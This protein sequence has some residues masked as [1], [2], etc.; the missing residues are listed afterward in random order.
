M[1]GRILRE[2]PEPNRYELL[3]QMALVLMGLSYLA[4]LL[5][6]EEPRHGLPTHAGKSWGEYFSGVGRILSRRPDF[7][8]FLSAFLVADIPLVLFS[9]FLTRYGLGHP[10]VPE[11]VT[12]TFTMVFFGAS[13]LGSIA[14]GWFSD[15]GKRRGV[16]RVCPVLN[17]CAAGT[18]MASSRPAAVS[19]AFA[20]FGLAFGMRMV[21]VLPA[22]FRYAGPHR[23]S[24]Y[25]AL[26]LT[27]LGLVGF[28]M[29]P[30][31]GWMLDKGLI[32]FRGMFAA[33][34]VLS[35]I[36]W[37]MFVRIPVPAPPEDDPPE[38]F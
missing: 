13:A 36:A 37:A 6:E 38:R 2:F 25:S 1:V 17:L 30:P 19:V 21:A 7:R 23:R 10:N 14:A 31:V 16:F 22:V 8:M 27:V 29:P 20:F 3:V 26:T 34:A 9:T 18:A 11:G 35:V 33:C 12:G 15:A 5:V 24:T 28:V 32:T 4:A